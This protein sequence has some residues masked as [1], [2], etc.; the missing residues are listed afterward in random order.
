MGASGPNLLWF[1]YQ[2]CK[3]AIFKLG[4]VLQGKRVVSILL[5]LYLQRLGSW[6]PCELRISRSFPVK[7]CQVTLEYCE[8][9]VPNQLRHYLGI[10]E[11]E[12]WPRKVHIQHPIDP[13]CIHNIRPSTS[14]L[15]HDTT[16]SICTQCMAAWNTCLCTTQNPQAWHGP[17]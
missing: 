17:R 13:F 16:W 9:C 11:I 8:F 14:I 15:G 7:L 10:M 6:T 1:C 5:Y 4:P 12:K 2:G 3:L